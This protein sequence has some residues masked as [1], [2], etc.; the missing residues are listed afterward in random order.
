M[1]ILLLLLL[2]SGWQFQ[3]S[4]REVTGVVKSETQALANVV[5]SDGTYFARTNSEGKF[6]LKVSDKSDFVYLFTPSGYSAPFSSGVP[7]FYQ[8]LEADKNTYNFELQQLPFGSERFALLATADPQTKTI[9]HFKRFEEQS[10]PDLEATI[11]AF[12]QKKVNPIGIALG[13]IAWDELFLFQNYKEAVAGLNIPFYPVIGNHDH[14]ET[15]NDDYG[16]EAEYRKNFGPTYYGFNLGKRHYIVLDNIVY[17]GDKKY[18]EDLTDHQI[19][20]VKN[21]LKLIPAG[22]E[23]IF[24]MHAPFKNLRADKMIPHGQQLLDL[25]KDYKVS[26]MSGHTHL[27]S[28]AEVAPGIIEH[29][30]GALCGTWWTAEVCRDGTPNGYQVFEMA[31]DNYSW[32]YKSV[33][34]TKDYQFEVYHPGQVVNNPNAVVAKV[35]NWDPTWKVEWFED[36][37]RKGEMTRFSS[38]DPDYLRYLQQNTKGGLETVPGYKQPVKTFFYF[39]AS[40]SLSAKTVKVRVSD[41]FGNQYE[42]QIE[43]KS[44]D[45]AAHRGGAG[46]LPENTIPA[47]L[48]A[49][50]L[51]VNTLELDLHLSAD[52]KVIVVH[53]AHFNTGHT[54]SPEGKNLSETQAKKLYFY[55]LNYNEIAEYDVGSKK[56]PRFPDQQKISTHIPL[57]SDLI[58]SVENF[59]AQNGYGP[60]VYNIEIKASAELEK[61]GLVPR[62]DKFVEQAMQVL[63]AK[64]LGERLI[65]QSFDTRT[66]KYLHKHYPNTRISYLVENTNTVKAN[67][68]LLDFV[69][70]IY[71]PYHPMVD[72]QLMNDCNALGMKVIPWTIDD[73]E[74]IQ[75][76]LQFEVDGII[77]NYPNRILKLTRGY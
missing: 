39:S 68:Q 16:S 35:W 69:P 11:S 6:S 26:F 73:T 25:C 31:P 32:Y 45:V 50:K 66:L 54:V 37:Q 75:K 27:N 43:L 64:N 47:M 59:T 77:S 71:S 63:Q 3:T 52:G 9:A 46:L 61:A 51:G 2:F 17:K 49:V 53:D 22:E 4:S 15:V 44:V 20:W 14:D 28:N 13:D 23:L 12:Q 48:N 62:F 8:A 18:D 58:D 7:Q 29:N 74:T 1:K 57:L 33:G 42:K 10:I 60:M 21:Y 70:E 5:V 36:G 24:A 65:M 67:M 56:Y 34:K 40:P 41:P 38:Y 55:Q 19:E 76:I 72:Q 30:V